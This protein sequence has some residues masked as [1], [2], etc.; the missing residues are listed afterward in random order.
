MRWRWKRRWQRRRRLG[1]RDGDRREEGGNRRRGEGR[2][3][4]RIRKRRRRKEGEGT[5]E[6]TGEGQAEIEGDRKKKPKFNKALPF[7]SYIQHLQTV[8][9]K[10]RYYRP[11]ILYLHSWK[12]KSFGSPVSACF[13]FLN[14]FGGKM[15]TD[16]NSAY[17]K[18]WRDLTRDYLLSYFT[19]CEFVKIW[20]QKILMYLITRDS[21]RPR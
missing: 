11:T 13:V 14:S 4:N 7:V 1:K 9:S 18:I 10:Q 2:D 8:L 6:G 21:L 3:G 19:H 15:W 20:L 16:L 17:S 12:P 5:R